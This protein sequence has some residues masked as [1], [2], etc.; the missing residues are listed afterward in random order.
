MKKLFFYYNLLFSKSKVPFSLISSVLKS[1]VF[2]Q[3]EKD[4]KEW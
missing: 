1:E 4:K 3:R 2:D